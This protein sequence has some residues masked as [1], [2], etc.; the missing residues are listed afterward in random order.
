M[1][2]AHERPRLSFWQIWNMSFGFL[3]IQFGWGLQMANMTPIYKYLGADE[4][5]IS[6]LWLAGPLTGLLI[7][8][9]IGAMSDRTWTRLGRRRPYFLVGAVLAS[10]ALVAMPHS[11]AVWMAAGLL[12][13]LDA[14]IN[15]TMEPFRAFV[16]DKLPPE[17]RTG[18]FVM[19]SFFIGIGQT[20]A[21][22]LPYVL[23]TWLGVHGALASGIP[24]STYFAFLI[25]AAA[26]LFAVLWT[27]LSTSEDP[28]A[29]LEAFRREH[30]G[31]GLLSAFTSIGPALREMPRTMKQLALVQFFTWL[32]LPCM[33]QYFGV[34]VARHV[35]HAVNPADPAQ[36]AL[37]EEGTNWGGLCFA[38]YN[39]VCFA[40]A[41][42]LSPVAWRFG[43]RLTHALCLA[44]GGLGLLAT[45][46]CTTRYA[47][48]LPMAAVGIAWASILAL[49]YALLA[50][51]VLPARMGFY[52]GVF[53]LFIVIPQVVMSFVMPLIYKPLL[54]GDPLH[55]V[56][57][58][59]ASLL[60]AAFTM[61]FVDAERAPAGK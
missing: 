41:F 40:V 15:V 34:A 42:L 32:A 38:V 3:G 18:G 53:N 49:P 4:A 58:G 12:W 13:I 1:T 6:Y 48:W 30:R 29:D 45:G 20:L 23:A 52:M 2:S 17:Q 7:Q 19:Q 57:L 24:R 9:I 22:A 10:L 51:S 31:S 26:F 56:M 28:P 54:A 36:A 47:L 33:W 11:S 35:F 27:V 43:I 46:W 21:N 60:V 61:R 14:S 44:I 16:G 39:V 37:M 55:A 50:G 8:P 25:G 59:G 5:N